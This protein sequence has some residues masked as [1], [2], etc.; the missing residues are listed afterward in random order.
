MRATAVVVA[1]LLLPLASHPDSVEGQWCG[2]CISDYH[3]VRHTNGE[4]PL[5]VFGY[6]GPFHFSSQPGLCLFYHDAGCSNVELAMRHDVTVLDL[7]PLVGHGVVYN[8]E[9]RSLQVLSCDGVSF[10]GNFPMT[11]LEVGLLP[12]ET[13][14]PPQT[15]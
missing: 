12:E 13:S 1:L 10:V 11:D 6:F 3:A 5:I 14:S 4:S 15:R 8:A 2:D 7:I 9:R